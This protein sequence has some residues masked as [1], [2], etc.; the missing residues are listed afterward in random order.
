MPPT[1][2]KHGLEPTTPARLVRTAKDERR[3]GIRLLIISAVTLAVMLAL[4]WLVATTNSEGH[5]DA[6][7][8]PLF[9]L[10]PLL[11][12]LYHLFHARFHPSKH[13]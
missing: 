4:W 5:H 6:Q 3:Q 11:P 7:L 2:E 9:T 8:L 10:I 12:A 1:H 13:E